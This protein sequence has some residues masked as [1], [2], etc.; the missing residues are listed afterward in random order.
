[1]TRQLGIRDWFFRSLAAEAR[2]DELETGGLAVR[3]A[4]DPRAAQRVLSLE[5][6]SPSVR[7]DAMSALPAYLAFFCLESS[8][9]EL[10]VERLLERH[11]SAWWESCAPVAIKKRVQSRR[12]NEGKARWHIQRGASEIAYT[13]F[14]DLL[15][16]ITTNWSDFTD[17]FPDQSWIT[18]R[19]SELEAS[20]NIIAHMNLLD[21][22]ELNRLRLYLRDWSRQVS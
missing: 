9:R 12:D 1:L 11:G 6:F 10:I 20:R 14:G 15:S 3:A 21:D 7:Q 13:D 22:A 8:V 2:L 4:S 16:I 19:L 5:E 17:L 18:T